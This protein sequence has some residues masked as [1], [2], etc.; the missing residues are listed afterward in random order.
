VLHVGAKLVV[1]R[2]GEVVVLLHDVWGRLTAH[3]GARFSNAQRVRSARSRCMKGIYT[4]SDKGKDMHYTE[5]EGARRRRFAGDVLTVF[6]LAHGS[7][8]GKLGSVQ[9]GAMA[10]HVTAL[11]IRK[12]RGITRRYRHKGNVDGE[13]RTVVSR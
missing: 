4:C 12:T 9:P 3:T 8:R 7:S 2:G 6:R 11:Q 1:P 10:K 5:R 13:C